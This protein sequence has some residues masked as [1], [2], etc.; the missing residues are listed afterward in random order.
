M[1]QFDCDFPCPI[2]GSKVTLFGTDCYPEEGISAECSNLE[3]DYELKIS[4]SKRIDCL[5]E[6]VKN[7]HSFIYSRKDEIPNAAH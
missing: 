7:A 1:S 3:C 5:R 6:A 4:C 2:C